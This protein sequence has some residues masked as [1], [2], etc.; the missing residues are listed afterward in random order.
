MDRLLSPPYI[1]NSLPLKTGT[2]EAELPLGGSG[3][4]T[5]GDG[6]GSA[7]FQIIIYIK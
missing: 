5:I 3:A 7:Q 6:K 4:C 1:N 2:T